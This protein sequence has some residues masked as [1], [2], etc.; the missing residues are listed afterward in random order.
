MRFLTI[1]K[2]EFSTNVGYGLHDAG[3]KNKG[4]YDFTYVFFDTGFC[5]NALFSMNDFI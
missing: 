1:V 2:Y 3:H 5:I 4:I